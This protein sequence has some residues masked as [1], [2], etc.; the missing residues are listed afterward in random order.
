MSKPTTIAVEAAPLPEIDDN[1]WGF[2][3]ESKWHWRPVTSRVPTI[4]YEELELEPVVRKQSVE[5]QTLRARP[6]DVEPLRR[7]CA[8][9]AHVVRRDRS[10]VKL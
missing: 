3:D 4:R 8:R 9:Q 6:Q 7:E 10:A 5:L 1:P 2:V